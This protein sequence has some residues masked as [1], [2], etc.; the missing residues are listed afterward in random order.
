MNNDAKIRC[1]NDI[2]KHFFKKF[3]YPIKDF[4]SI[5]FLI[6]FNVLNGK[7]PAFGMNTR[8]VEN[9]ILISCMS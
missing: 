1:L 4:L 6:S 9:S 2:T 8:D 5:T 7:Y 3:Y